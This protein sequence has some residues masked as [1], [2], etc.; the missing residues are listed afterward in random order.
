MAMNQRDRFFHWLSPIYDCLIRRPEVDRLQA[1][2]NLPAK[3]CLLDLGGG[4]GRVAQHFVEPETKVV[5]C[6]INRSMLNQAKRKKGLLPLQANAAVLPFPSESFDGILV[7]DALHHFLEPRRIADEMSRVVKPRGRILIE[8]QDIRRHFIKL[9]S[10]AE[11]AVG[12]HSSFLSCR[13]ILALFDPGRYRLYVERG[14]FFT[15]RVLIEA[16]PRQATGRLHR[17]DK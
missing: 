15:F 11:K 17:K 10:M 16:S 14:N 2:L 5:V 7:V 12:L 13:E 1:L 4:T 6:D 9:V 3:S 8:E